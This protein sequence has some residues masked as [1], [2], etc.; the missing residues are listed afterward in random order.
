MHW[1]ANQGDIMPEEEAKPKSLM[2]KFTEMGHSS[3]KATTEFLAVIGPMAFLLIMMS[4]AL[5]FGWVKNDQWMTMGKH[6]L[7]AGI[8]YAL[9]RTGLKGVDIGA[10]FLK[11]ATVKKDG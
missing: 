1:A 5:A 7:D 11:N 3:G 6:V 9:A 10:S 4:I 2:D 8:Y